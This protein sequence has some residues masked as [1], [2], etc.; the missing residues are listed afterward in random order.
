LVLAVVPAFAL[1][2]CGT[3]TIDP[4][5]AAALIKKDLASGV[6][7][8]SVHCPSGVKAKAGTTFSCTVQLVRTGDPTVHTGSVTVHIT[9]NSGHATVSGSDFHVQ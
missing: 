5:K 1:A 2:A 4:S 7:A 3:T 6:T 9:S 8:K